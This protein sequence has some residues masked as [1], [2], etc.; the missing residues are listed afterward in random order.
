MIDKDFEMV[1]K[2]PFRTH[3]L[4]CIKPYFQEICSG[5]KQFELRKNDRNYQVGDT[6]ILREYHPIISGCDYTGYLAE[7]TITYILENVP[8]FGLKDG[9]AILGIELQRRLI[10]KELAFKFS[11]RYQEYQEMEKEEKNEN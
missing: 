5:I 8:L 6:L 7:V 9:Y 2:Q 10:D 4:K 11:K 3:E 1:E